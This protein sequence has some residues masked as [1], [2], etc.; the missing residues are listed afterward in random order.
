M[1]NKLYL[2]IVFI[3]LNFS[4]ECYAQSASIKD[5]R[6]A[7]YIDLHDYMKPFWK[8]SVI[9]DETVM[10]IREGSK[11]KANLLFS[12]KEIL[13]VTST[14]HSKTY[15]ENKDWALKDGRL[16]I[17]NSSTV[18]FFNA[19]DLLFYIQKPNMSMGAKKPGHYILFKEGLY[20]Q[21]YQVSVSYRKRRSSRWQ[22]PRTDV[23]GDKL[24][25]TKKLLN[26]RKELKVC[27]YGN[28]I[29]TGYNSS[30][31][32]GGPPYMPSWPELVCWKL[33]DFFKSDIRYFNP[34]VAG[35]MAKWG[36]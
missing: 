34:S 15:L 32:I 23:R 16:D 8:S 25:R 11:I 5:A 36:A 10:V 29:E 3:S 31:F 21:S 1:N 30:G 28:S 4:M 33:H 9:N 20:F 13:S 18:P 17:L 12:A 24:S 35:K 19:T 27:Y 7:K 22:G 6:Y 2:L 14:D 26:S